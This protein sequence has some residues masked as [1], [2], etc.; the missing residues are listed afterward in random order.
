MINSVTKSKK[1]LMCFSD[2]RGLIWCSSTLPFV[3]WESNADFRSSLF[4][5]QSQKQRTPSTAAK[6]Q[7]S[8]CRWG[9]L[10]SHK[11]YHIWRLPLGPL[12]K[13][14][15]TTMCLPC[16]YHSSSLMTRHVGSTVGGKHQGKTSRARLFYLVVASWC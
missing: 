6:W 4:F 13:V 7:H 2:Q 8:G 10:M 5:N 1:W 16:V 14:L 3:L 9:Y 12:N 15:H 11:E